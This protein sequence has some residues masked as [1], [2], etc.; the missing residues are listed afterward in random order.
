MANHEKVAGRVPL[1]PFLFAPFFALLGGCI[2]GL[3][4]E[5]NPLAGGEIW[6]VGFTGPKGGRGCGSAS[7][8]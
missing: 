2:Q 4:F 5:S 1:S 7:R 3:H 6:R 8:A